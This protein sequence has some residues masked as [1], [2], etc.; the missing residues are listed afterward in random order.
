MGSCTYMPT[1]VICWIHWFPQIGIPP[2]SRDFCRYPHPHYSFLK[3]AGLFLAN[4]YSFTEKPPLCTISQEQWSGK[5]SDFGLLALSVTSGAD[6]CTCG[7]HVICGR[8]NSHWNK[9]TDVLEHTSCLLC[10][11]LRLD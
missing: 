5:L 9:S 3:I 4:N 1:D 11:K 2:T 7:M 10:L 6:S 8:Q